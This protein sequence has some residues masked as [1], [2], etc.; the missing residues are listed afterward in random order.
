VRATLAAA[1]ALG[2]RVVVAFQPHRYTRT[3]D[4]LEDFATAFYQ[5]D[6]VLLTAI[7]AAGEDPIAGI[8][9]ERLASEIAQHG[10]KHV[11]H[12]GPRSELVPALLKMVR[13]GDLVL[14][15]GA[16]D[17]TRTGDELLAALRA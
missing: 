14:T 4:L 5:A 3:R 17:I 10:H 15:L 1:R 12:V 8:T 16:G 7:Y 13:P 11:D 9:G 6:V 2:R